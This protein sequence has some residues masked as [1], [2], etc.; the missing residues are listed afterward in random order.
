MLVV[1]FL[2]YMLYLK[3]ITSIKSRIIFN[4]TDSTSKKHKLVQQ[5]MCAAGIRNYEVGGVIFIRCLIC[6]QIP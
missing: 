2:L 1:F 5:I 4:L 3:Y 6:G